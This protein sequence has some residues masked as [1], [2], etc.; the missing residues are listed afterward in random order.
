MGIMDERP[1]SDTDRVAK[2][3]LL[4]QVLVDRHGPWDTCLCLPEIHDVNA[5]GG[6]EDGLGFG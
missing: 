3:A 4:D 2:E 5:G 1:R 6:L